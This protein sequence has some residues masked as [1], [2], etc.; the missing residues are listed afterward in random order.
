M[1]QLLNDTVLGWVFITCV[2]LFCSA[3]IYAMFGLPD[4]KSPEKKDRK[5]TPIN[6]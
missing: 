5:R 1:S 3:I 4:Y 2:L 6:A